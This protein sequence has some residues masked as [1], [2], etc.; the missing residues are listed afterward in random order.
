MRLAELAVAYKGKGVV[1]FDLAGAEEGHPARRHREAVQL[2]HDNNVNVTIHAGE[3]YGPESI[4]QAVHVCGA[5]RIGHGVRLRENGELLNYLNDH[6]IPLEMCPSSNVQTGSVTSFAAHPL[7]FFF[8]FGLRVSVNTD[9]RLMSGTTLTDEYLHAASG[10]GFTFD[11]LAE[12][13]L[14]GFASA[15]L[16]WEER[17]RLLANARRDIALL[18]SGEAA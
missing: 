9:N 11:E 3:A 12:I 17:Q 14:N 13:A 2:I 4:A 18:R 6:R 8:D 7:K 5:N 15:F 10:L 16:P 1:G